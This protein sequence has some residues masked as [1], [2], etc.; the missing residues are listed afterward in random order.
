M[1]DADTTPN[2]SVTLSQTESMKYLGSALLCWPLAFA[3]LYCNTAQQKQ[4]LMLAGGFVIGYLIMVPFYFLCVCAMN[5]FFYFFIKHAPSS[6]CPTGV[7]FALTML[8]LLAYRL[9]DSYW[10][11]APERD[12]PT[13][14]SMMIWAY[15]M[16]SL[17]MDVRGA[18]L[19]QGRGT[20]AVLVP[21]KPSPSVLDFFAYMFS[22]GGIC[23]GPVLQYGHYV[24]Y[25]G[26]NPTSYNPAAWTAL[27]SRVV[28][29]LGTILAYGVMVKVAGKTDLEELLTGWQ[30]VGH[31]LD[32][33]WYLFIHCMT[34]RIRYYVIWMLTEQTLMLGAVGT[35][36]NGDEKKG[37]AGGKYDLSRVSSAD[38]FEIELYC[39]AVPTRN[40]VQHMVRNWNM[41]IQRWLVMVVYR[42]FP[43][44]AGR[45]FAVF[46]VTAFM[47]GLSPGFYLFFLHLAAADMVEQAW[48]ST[49][50]KIPR[51]FP[52]A[53]RII[54]VVRHFFMFRLLEY[55]VVPH[56]LPKATVADCFKV[57]STLGYSGHIA[58]AL[59][60]AASVIWPMKKQKKQGDKK[61]GGKKSVAGKKEL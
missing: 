48:L 34:M 8:A 31:A 14:A 41:S 15:R 24:E 21:S 19:T 25:L 7:V 17:S 60:L 56:H 36:S 3:L 4:Y 11:G 53:E 32:M 29:M 27:K 2:S 49:D 61:D 35:T 50:L 1:E 58:M 18:A 52:G 55:I 5:V 28:Y 33:Y 16:N 40:A 47:H 54:A 9:T 39:C 12:G 6:L 42:R 59:M 13:G 37:G 20:D 51:S 45:T 38:P 57:W 30:G 10:A 43:I 44:K 23:A 46:A 22:F 26:L